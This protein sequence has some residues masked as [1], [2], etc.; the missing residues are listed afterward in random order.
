MDGGLTAPKPPEIPRYEVGAISPLPSHGQVVFQGYRVLPVP[1]YQAGSFPGEPAVLGPA[2]GG[3][4]HLCRT[5]HL[6]HK[7]PLLL[8]GIVPQ[9]HQGGAAAAD[10]GEVVQ[11]AGGPAPC[12]VKVRRS[13]AL[14]G[15]AARDQSSP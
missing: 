9:E 3:R 15:S 2:E 10:L 13:M 8:L 7:P 14:K 6:H 1:A 11:V 5:L 12:K 4:P